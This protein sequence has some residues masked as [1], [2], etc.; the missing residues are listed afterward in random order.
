MPKNAHITHNFLSTTAMVFILDEGYELGSY[1]E[2]TV[3]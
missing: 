2:A 3:V 1:I